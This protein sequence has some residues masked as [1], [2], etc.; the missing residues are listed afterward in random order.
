MQC[1]GII[2]DRNMH[3]HA[4]SVQVLVLLQ[5]REHSGEPEDHLQHCQHQQVKEPADEWP[6]ARGQVNL[7]V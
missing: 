7:K 5:H 4:F 2:V 6:H 1:N 3:F